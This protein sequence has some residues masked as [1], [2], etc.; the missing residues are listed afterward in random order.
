MDWRLAFAAVALAF[1]AGGCGHSEALTMKTM[2]SGTVQSKTGD[3]PGTIRVRRSAERGF[4]DHGW[5]RARHT[6][7]FAGY[8]DAQHM[9]FGPL[10]VINEDA[11]AG[12]TGFDT[13][14]HRDMEIITYVLSGEL[15]HA[16]SLGHRGVIRPG[17]VQ[18]ISAGRGVFHSERNPADSEP[19]HLLQ[20][21]IT[22]Q[23]KGGDPAYEQRSIRA[24]P[25][26][27]VPIVTP[28]GAGGTISIR[29]DA[30]V[31]AGSFPEGGAARREV[32]EGRRAWLQVAR[33]GVTLNGVALEAGDGA[34]VTGPLGLDLSFAPGAEALLFDLP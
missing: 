15:E 21:W 33:G 27:F 9:G 16:D 7:S 4:A 34:A 32:P 3:T 29:Q 12:G 24:T 6:F 5:L 13:H 8:F 20:V 25:G 17:E 18:R 19:V 11:V 28:D 2:N 14:P 1:I 31:L 23:E 26:V 30:T 22:P 10:R